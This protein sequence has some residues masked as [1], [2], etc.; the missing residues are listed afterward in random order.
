MKGGIK[1]VLRFAKKNGFAVL[2]TKRHTVLKLGSQVV[3]VAQTPSCP[4][5]AT[6]AIKDVERAIEQN[7]RD[8]AGGVVGAHHQD[9]VQVVRTG[10]SKLV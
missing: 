7:N 4:F 6:N 1:D 2:R 3:T 5:G 8:K 9:A 10:R